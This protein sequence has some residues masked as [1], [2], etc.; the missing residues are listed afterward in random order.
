LAQ[1]EHELCW[2]P[3]AQAEQAFFHRS[4]AWAARHILPKTGAG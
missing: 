1:A 2:L 4:H 3:V